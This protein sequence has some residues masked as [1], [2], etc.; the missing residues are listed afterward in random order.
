MFDLGMAELLKCLG[1]NEKQCNLAAISVV[2]R[3]VDPVA[4]N[5]LKEKLVINQV[6]A[7]RSCRVMNKN[8]NKTIRT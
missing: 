1:F 8:S 7:L 3:L 2:N 6:K 5:F 4:E